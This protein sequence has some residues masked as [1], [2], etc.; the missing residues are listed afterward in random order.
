MAFPYK[1]LF[2]SAG[3]LT[4]VADALVWPEQAGY[5]SDVVRPVD[6]AIGDDPKLYKL[7]LTFSRASSAAIAEDVAV[8]TFHLAKVTAEDYTSAWLPADFAAAEARFNTWWASVRGAVHTSCKLVDYRW[9]KSGPAFPKSGPPVR[10]TLRND[11]GVATANQVPPQVSVNVSEHTR[12]R[13]HWGRFYLPSFTA[14][15]FDTYGRVTAGRVGALSSSTTTL[16]NGLRG[17]G[18]PVMVYSP[19]KPVRPKKG[20]GTLPAAPARAFSV[21]AL[22]VD[23]I[24][25]V[26]RSRRFDRPITKA[27]TVTI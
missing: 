8:C 23:D 2:K 19:A 3:F 17:D 5:G 20:G 12:L 15:N 24:P 6:E 16:Y 4:Q 7:H 9:Y 22:V 11:A 25:D 10:I 13:K 27:T 18:T 14:D 1:L 26:I 21:E